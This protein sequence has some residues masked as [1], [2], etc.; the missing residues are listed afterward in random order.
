MNLDL[1]VV[2]RTAP[3]NSWKNH[4][5]RIMS[6][7]D[8]G[9]QSMGIMRM[10]G[11]EDSER[12]IKMQRISLNYEKKQVNW[13]RKCKNLSVNQLSCLIK[14]LTER[15]EKKFSILLHVMK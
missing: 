4:V 1:L 8:L 10:E 11:N 14:S 2:G 6:I 3:C 12:A 7:V 9:L 5:E 13:K 15:L